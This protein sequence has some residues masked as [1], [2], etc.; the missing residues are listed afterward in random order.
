MIIELKKLKNNNKKLKNIIF[1]TVKVYY[2]YYY[3]F[4]LNDP[5]RLQKWLKAL[6]R[7]SWQPTK[8]SFLCSQHFTADSYKS[9]LKHFLKDDAVPTISCFSTDHPKI[10]RKRTYDHLLPVS[11]YFLLKLH[12]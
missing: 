9:S 12:L 6:K 4:P 11:K 5:E 1:N 3:R 7:E 10:V 2:Y 8:H